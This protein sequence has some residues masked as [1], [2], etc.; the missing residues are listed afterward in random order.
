MFSGPLPAALGSRQLA[1]SGSGGNARVRECGRQQAAG[2]RLLSGKEGG[3]RARAPPAGG[4]RLVKVKEGE[5]GSTAV[6]LAGYNA[7]AGGADRAVA[8]A[9]GALER[10]HASLSH[11]KA[12]GCIA[13]PPQRLN[14]QG[15]EENDKGQGKGK[16]AGEASAGPVL[17]CSKR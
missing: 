11:T 17:F 12:D 15:E 16:A 5:G 8:V 4:R 14:T 2:G 10:W 1:R 6:G 3:E 13:R 7:Q 9:G